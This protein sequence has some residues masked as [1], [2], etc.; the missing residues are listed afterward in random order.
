MIY[1]KTT[2]EEYNQRSAYIRRNKPSKGH[3]GEVC[4]EECVHTR[5]QCS[6]RKFKEQSEEPI[7]PAVEKSHPEIDKLE[8]WMTAS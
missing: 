5:N 6:Q 4:P 3:V 2:E 7:R 8:R 1:L